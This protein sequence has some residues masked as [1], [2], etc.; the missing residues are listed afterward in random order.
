MKQINDLSELNELLDE[1]V[2]ARIDEDLVKKFYVELQKRFEIQCLTIIVKKCFYFD[3][4]DE[5]IQ[6]W[7]EA[8]IPS[9][10]RVEYF[11]N[12]DSFFQM[13]TQWFL[14][15]KEEK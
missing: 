12:E 15:L 3:E 9:R 7:Y 6:I 2:G 8:D 1:V 14:N 4:D 5:E 11:Q 10:K 13:V